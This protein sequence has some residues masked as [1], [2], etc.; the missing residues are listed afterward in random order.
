MANDSIINKFVNNLPF[1]LHLYDPV[2]GKYSACGPGTKH[3]DRIENYIKTG[4]TSHIFKND[5]DK[6]CFY[7]DSSYDKYKDVPNRQIADKKLMDGAYEIVSDQSRNGYER[8]LASMIYKFFEKKIQL[9]QGIQDDILVEELH[10]PIRHNF[11]RRKVVAHK[12]HQIWACDLVDMT[13]VYTDSGY[14]Y[15]LNVVD[16]FSKYAWSIPLKSKKTEELIE[17]FKRLFKSQKPEKLWWDEESG[18]YSEKFQLFLMKE[19]VSL[20][21]TGSEL[22]VTIVERFNRTLK[23]WMWK[24]FTRNGNKK[25]VNLLPALI[26]SYNNKVHSTIKMSPIEAVKDKNNQIVYER[27]YKMHKSRDNMNKAKFKVGDKVRI[28]RWKK[29]FEKGYTPNWS[30]ELFTVAD[31]IRTHPITYQI[32]DLNGEYILLPNQNTPAKFYAE[33]LQRSKL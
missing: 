10:K 22:G 8:M 19:N 28:Y 16:C 17:A 20:Y 23:Q 26:D 1:E 18:V 21:S 30:K 32:K 5:L 24:E 14:R 15:I 12:A 3:K 9:G 6:F 25:W 11:Q 27:L 29:E 4:D 13:S 7:H 2:V 31:V 33:E